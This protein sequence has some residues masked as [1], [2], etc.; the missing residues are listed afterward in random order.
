MY[1]VNCIVTIVSIQF[2]TDSI[3]RRAF[4]IK[5]KA[6]IKVFMKLKSIQIKG[7]MKE[8]IKQR[9]ENIWLF[10]WVQTVKITAIRRIVFRE[11]SVFR[12]E[13]PIQ[14]PAETSRTVTESDSRE[15]LIGPHYST[16]R[17]DF[18]SLDLGTLTRS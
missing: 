8:I 9:I 14:E 16:S 3:F 10:I 13:V 17:R 15:L 1:S 11:T 7:S 4:A 6:E 5:L 2:K 18:S 12:H